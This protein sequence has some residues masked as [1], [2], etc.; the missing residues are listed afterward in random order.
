MRD[1][2]RRL[3]DSDAEVDMVVIRS[4]SQTRVE[5]PEVL[6]TMANAPGKTARLAVL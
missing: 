6:R 4:E 5:R 3:E 2:T 1:C